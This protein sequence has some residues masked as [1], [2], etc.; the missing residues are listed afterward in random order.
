MINLNEH[1]SFIYISKF[2]NELDS[3]HKA[4]DSVAIIAITDVKGNIIKVNENF[5]NISGYSKEELLGKNHRIIKS[6]YHSTKF[7][8]DMFKKISNGDIWRGEIK[9][10]RKNGTYYWVDT[11]ITPILGENN[12]PVNYLALRFDIT[13]RKNQEFKN[14]EDTKKNENSLIAQNV[15]KNKI[16]YT[17]SHDIKEPLRSL[18]GSLNLIT[19]DAISKDQFN[20][21]VDD[22]R[23]K[24]NKVDKLI[25]GLI[26]VAE[27][28]YTNRNS[29][30]NINI[31]EIIN[32]IIESS[33]ELFS[34]KKVYIKTKFKHATNIW[35]HKDL[36]TIIIRNFVSNAIKFS[37][38]EGEVLIESFSDKL[39]TTIKI[40]DNGVGISKDEL[41]IIKSNLKLTSKG[42][43]NE[44]G[45]GIG[46]F[47]CRDLIFDLGGEFTVESKKGKGST[48]GFTFPHTNTKQKNTIPN[49]LVQIVGNEPRARGCTL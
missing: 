37:H 22:I 18:D 16:L 38:P 11:V 35:S 2:F 9:N 48:F 13:N 42:T 15:F 12:K 21:M 32:E 29:L 8:T 23:N 36:V 31:E 41:Q 7:F 28:Y 39:M 26:S 27:S 5:C 10:K 45:S 47:I 19:L 20:I 34:I 25:E 1:T 24:I 14:Q 43:A 49:E 30:S 46:L 17:L 4:I 44:A 40:I 3:Y 33:A 6:S